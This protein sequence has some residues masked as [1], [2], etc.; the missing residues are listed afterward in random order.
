MGRGVKNT[1]TKYIIIPKEHRLAMQKG[2]E[3]GKFCTWKF[4]WIL[5]KRNKRKL[6][7]KG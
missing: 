6:K 5:L 7:Y 1:A 4:L 2:R 3:G